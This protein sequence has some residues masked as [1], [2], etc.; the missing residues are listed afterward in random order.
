MLS[1]LGAPGAGAPGVAGANR[2]LSPWPPARSPTFCL[3]A[4]TLAAAGE[5]PDW[6]QY[7]AYLNEFLFGEVG[8]ITYDFSHWSA[9]LPVGAAYL[10]SAAAFVLLVQR[11]R[12]LVDGERAA[13]IALCGITAY[14]IALFSYFVNRSADHILPYVSLPALMAGILWLSLLLRGALVESRTAALGGAGVRPA[15]SR[16]CWSP[17]HGRRSVRGSRGR[18]WLTSFP[19]ASRL[20]GPS[21]ASGTRRRST[22]G[23]RRAKPCS[24]ATCRATDRVPI[25][26]TPDLETEILIRSDRANGLGLSYPTE[27]SFVTAR[28]PAARAAGGGRAATR[29]SAADADRRAQGA[30][31][32]SEPSPR[33]TRSPTRSTQKLLAP[34]Q[35]WALKRIGQRFRIRVIHRDDDSWSPP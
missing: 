3:A 12:D 18:R 31:R 4:A 1:S 6:G 10:A 30:R 33:G 24:I 29:R 8:D 32:V 17:L 28:D 9:G 16:S 23:H 7:L 14:G 5:L 11:R 2:R 27:D 20:V 15:R 13:L 34:L 21:T 25:I 22:P 19:A 35:E 26:V